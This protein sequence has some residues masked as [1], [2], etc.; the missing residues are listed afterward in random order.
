MLVE[1]QSGFAG[2]VARLN[3][4]VSA[5]AGRWDERNDIEEGATKKP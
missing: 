5:V 4:N 1:H 2:S 3:L